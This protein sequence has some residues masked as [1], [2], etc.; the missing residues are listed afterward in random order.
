VIGQHMTAVLRAIGRDPRKDPRDVAREYLCRAGERYN[1][2]SGCV[3]ALV[4]SGFSDGAILTALEDTYRGLF[5]AEELRDHMTAFYAAPAGL[6]SCLSRSMAG[7][8]LPVD[9]LDEQL[10][11]ANWSLFLADG[12]TT[13]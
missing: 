10:C 5:A 6:R 4:I 2:M 9:E 11:V 1:T 13:G 8:V 3:G 12:D 7:P